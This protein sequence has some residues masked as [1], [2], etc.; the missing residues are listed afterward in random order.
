MP[1]QPIGIASQSSAHRIS[2]PQVAAEEESVLRLQIGGS[3]SDRLQVGVLGDRVSLVARDA[4]L[5][6]V[7]GMIA[8]QHRLNIVSGEDVSARISV[9]LTDVSL[10]DALDSVLLIHGYC[11]ARHND[12]I[13]VS[14]LST[15]RKL[16]PLAQGRV[17]RVFRLNYLTATDVDKVVKGLLSPVGQSFTLETNPADK[18]RTHEQLIVEDLPDSV[19]RIEQCVWQIDQPPRQVLV[20]ANVLQVTLEDDSRHGVN[21]QHILDIANSEVTVGATGFANPLAS[22]AGFLRIDGSHLDSFIECIKATNDAKTLATP[23]LVVLNGQEA[24]IQIG[25]QLGYLLT[26]TTQTS[27]M[28]SVNFLELGVIL[29]VTPIITDDGNVLLQ[30]KP[31]VSSGEI[32]PD[33][34]LPDS[35][36]TEVETKVLLADGQAIVIGG[37]IKDTDNESQSKIPVLGDLWLI[38]RLFQRRTITRERNEIIITLRPHIA[39]YPSDLHGRD[40]FEVLRADTRLLNPNLTKV[41]RPYEPRLPDAGD[42]PW[43]RRLPPVSCCQQAMPAECGP[44]MPEVAPVPSGVEELPLGGRVERTQWR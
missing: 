39:P 42:P 4:A 37:L 1:R 23:R 9:T 32:N 31:E 44:A 25:Q 7:L 15:E 17:V 33:T 11:W 28:E 36:T 10:S 13:I 16:A 20:E 26:T 34:G 19:A 8:E 21:F 3:P 41:P 40:Q 35:E 22:P 12:I 5:G 27:T 18:R 29:R 38:G 6:E 30:V 43:I 24:K 14:K 2:A